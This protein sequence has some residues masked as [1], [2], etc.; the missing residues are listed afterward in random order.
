M[1]GAALDQRLVDERAFVIHSAFIRV[2][3]PDG[4]GRPLPDGSQSRNYQGLLPSQKGH[5]FGPANT[6]VGGYQAVDK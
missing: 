4:E 3:T 1:V 5:G 6:D 2:D